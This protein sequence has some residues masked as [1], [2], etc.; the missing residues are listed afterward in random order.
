MIIFQTIVGCSSHHFSTAKSVAERGN[1][2]ATDI[3]CH[4]AACSKRNKVKQQ[5]MHGTFV[6]LHVASRGYLIVQTC[7][8]ACIINTTYTF[9][10]QI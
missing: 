3:I 9:S 7:N 8:A 1:P 4:S 2:G 5:L 6:S 10:Q